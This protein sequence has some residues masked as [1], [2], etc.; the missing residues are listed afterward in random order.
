MGRKLMASVIVAIAL[1]L[2]ANLGLLLGALEL[3]YRWEWLHP[4][5]ATTVVIPVGM[6]L[7]AGF[8]Y[9]GWAIGNRWEPYLGEYFR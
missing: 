2:L 1:A 6:G 3:A 8:T 9:T 5:M 7:A 4:A